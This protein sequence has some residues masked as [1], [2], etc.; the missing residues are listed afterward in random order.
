MVDGAS[1]MVAPSELSGSPLVRA[2]MMKKPAPSAPVMNRLR[3]LISHPP[4]TLRAVV[5]NAAGSDPAPG[6]GSVIA[7]AERHSPATRGRR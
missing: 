2:M 6:P 1:N 3:P 7:K 4:S 5:D